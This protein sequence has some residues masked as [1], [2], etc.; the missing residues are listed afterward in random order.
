MQP[1]ADK[2]ADARADRNVGVAGWKACST[3]Q[4]RSSQRSKMLSWC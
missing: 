3:G 4:P 2:S 1:G